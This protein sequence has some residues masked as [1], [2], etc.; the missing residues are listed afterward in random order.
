[1]IV[2]PVS[3]PPLLEYLGFRNGRGRREYLL[4]LRSI[5]E[6]RDYTVWIADAAFA[7]RRVLFQDGPA[8]CYQKLQ[9]VL[10]SAEP[11][12]ERCFEVTDAELLEYKTAHTPPT[13]QS[14][15][16]KPKP[17]PERA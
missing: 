11:M 3:R 12:D 6:V 14:F 4:A 2:A 5:D 7:E 17:T 8:V 13:R 16:A 10:A 1:V 9:R 15:G